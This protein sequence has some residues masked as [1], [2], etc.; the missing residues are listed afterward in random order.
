METQ[1]M[2]DCLKR[3]FWTYS[4]HYVDFLEIVH[5]QLFARE[6]SNSDSSRLCTL[7]PCTRLG[8][9]FQQR[10]FARGSLFPPCTLGPARSCIRTS[11]R[12]ACCSFCSRHLWR[13]AVRSSW[14]DGGPG[15]GGC[16][17]HAGT[18]T[19][20]RLNRR[21]P[22]IPGICRWSAVLDIWRSRTVATRREM[23]ERLDPS[24]KLPINQTLLEALEIDNR[25]FGV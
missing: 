5:Q 8:C 6:N 16:W 19:P 21:N 3:N 25:R 12:D 4:K 20:V 11:S 9:R 23:Q 1:Q 10:V 24:Q 13:G 22:S 18:K 15:C 17:P 14:T 2:V 7:G